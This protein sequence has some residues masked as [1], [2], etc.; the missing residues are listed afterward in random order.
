MITLF[1]ISVFTVGY[2]YF[3]YPLVLYILNKVLPERKV[4]QGEIFPEVTLIISVYNEAATIEEKLKNALSLDYPK[5]KL[6]ILVVSDA[7][8]DGSDDII[9]GYQDQGK[10]D[11]LAERRLV[12]PGLGKALG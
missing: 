3:G 8:T 11:F 10:H 7:S 2:V 9:R 5:E 6:E 1:W 12:F 4:Q